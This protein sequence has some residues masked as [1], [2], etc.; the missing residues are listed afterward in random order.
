M[1]IS[2]LCAKMAATATEIVYMACQNSDVQSLANM[3]QIDLENVINTIRQTQS[4]RHQLQSFNDFVNIY[5]Q[6]MSETKDTYIGSILSNY[7]S[8]IMDWVK[9][10]WSRELY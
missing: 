1:D 2:H 4:G 3:M 10:F 7:Q 9:E 8:I 6:I 5:P